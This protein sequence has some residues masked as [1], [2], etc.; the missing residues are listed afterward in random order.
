MRLRSPTTRNLGLPAPFTRNRLTRLSELSV[1]STSATC[2]SI[3]SVPAPSSELIRLEG[4]TCRVPIRKPEALT[5]CSSSL[6]ASQLVKKSFER[7]HCL[8]P[9]TLGYPFFLA[10]DVFW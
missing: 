9:G 2:T 4:S 6:K 3:V 10:Y 1:I 7:E 8:T 5:T